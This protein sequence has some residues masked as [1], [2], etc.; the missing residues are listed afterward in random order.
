MIERNFDNYFEQIKGVASKKT[1][2]S[3][4]IEN[5][6]VPVMVNGECEVVM[7][8]LPQPKTEAAPFIENRTHS[9]KG[10]DGKWHVVDCLRKSGSKC[11]ICDWNSAVFKAFPKEKAKELAKKKAKRAFVSNVYIVKNTAA[12]NTEGKVYRFKY[13]IQIMEKILEKMADHEDPDK[14][15]IKGINV[16]DYY[17]GANLIFKAKEGPYGPNPKDSYFGDMKPISDKNNVPLDETEVQAIDDQLL[18]LKPCEKDTSSE[19]FESVLNVYEKF[20][21]GEKLYSRVS[22]AEGKIT[23]EPIIPGI[24]SGN[25]AALNE[26]VRSEAAVDEPDVRPT[27]EASDDFLDSLL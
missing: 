7:R 18:E 3:F 9:F 23:Y 20:S 26:S 4:S 24:A 14:G 22:D 13:G 15:L 12:P 25:T 8:L 1:G 21:D 6:F 2:S 27:A 5:E 19:T 10:P 11:P 16:F 17:N